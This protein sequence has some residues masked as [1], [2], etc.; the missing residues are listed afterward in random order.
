MHR[1]MKILEESGRVLRDELL[2][3][4][5]HSQADID[6]V[7]LEE[8][9]V[10]DGTGTATANREDSLLSTGVGSKWYA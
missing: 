6:K 7:R 1:I 2:K 9:S 5:K 3:Q 10:D 8:G 4:G